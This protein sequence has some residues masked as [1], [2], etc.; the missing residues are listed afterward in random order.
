MQTISW[1][2]YPQNHRSQLSNQHNLNYYIRQP[3]YLKE[4]FTKKESQIDPA[5]SESFRYKQTVRQKSFFNFVVITGGYM[6]LKGLDRQ[7]PINWCTFPMMI[8]NITPSVDNS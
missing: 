8:H 4:K 2:S 5:V 3:P 1:G 6:D 7:W